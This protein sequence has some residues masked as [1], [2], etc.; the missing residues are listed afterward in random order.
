MPKVEVHHHLVIIVPEELP[1]VCPNCDQKL[2][3]IENG[4]FRSARLQRVLHSVGIDK[5]GQQDD[6]GVTGRAQ[7]AYPGSIA[8]SCTSCG[9]ELIPEHKRTYIL[10]A[11]DSTLAFKLRGLLYDSNVKH[12]LI[13]SKC[14]T[15]SAGYH[16][17]CLACNIETEIGTEEVPH[18]VDPRVHTCKKQSA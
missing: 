13:R 5:D 4:H 10:E 12:E 15:E 7:S 8:Y 6:F 1:E 11:M 3:D 14:F 9:E 17:D 18:P 16:G 2:V